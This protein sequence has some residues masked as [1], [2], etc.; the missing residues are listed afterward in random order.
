MAVER[1]VLATNVHSSRAYLHV[2]NILTIF[3]QFYLRVSLL[4]LTL[5][6]S[7]HVLL[8]QAA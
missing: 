3:L 1:S 6:F 4:L 5:V 2:N 7:Y 8:A